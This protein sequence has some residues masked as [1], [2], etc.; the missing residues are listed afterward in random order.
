MRSK[1]GHPSKPS[2]GHTPSPHLSLHTRKAQVPARATIPEAR[3]L[4]GRVD[5]NLGLLL[6]HV[7]EE[8][9]SDLEESQFEREFGGTE[10]VVL[11]RPNPPMQM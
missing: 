10:R 11:K 5:P 8:S 1:S 7:H 9:S 2:H 4:H 6:S 3:T